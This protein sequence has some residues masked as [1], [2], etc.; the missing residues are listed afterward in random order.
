M[1]YIYIVLMIL[2]C[3]SCSYCYLDN[4]DK[5]ERTD[6]DPLELKPDLEL[7]KL[8]F[9]LIRQTQIKR[10]KNILMEEEETV[11]KDMPYHS[12]G[13][14]LGN[15]LFFDLRRNLSLCVTD[16]FGLEDRDFIIRITDDTTR[17]GRAADYIYRNDSLQ[18]TR[19]NKKRLKYR[20]HIQRKNEEIA[21][22]NAL[23]HKKPDNY[24]RFG[25][26]L[27]EWRNR[28]RTLKTIKKQADSSYIVLDRK[29]KRLMKCKMRNDTVELSWDISLVYSDGGRCI[30]VYKKYFNDERRYWSIIHSD[31]ELLVYD[32]T[33]IGYRFVFHDNCIDYYDGKKFILRYELID[34]E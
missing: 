11:T 21:I 12:I 26:S 2:F 31:N 32:K 3:S 7:T 16:L 34:M 33:G 10:E 29:F 17:I 23:R 15:G 30:E 28:R 9:D 5:V 14:Y 13:F 24:Y 18:Y 4:I 27:F 25:D 20:Y 22:Y 8:R 19:A 6:F 1:R